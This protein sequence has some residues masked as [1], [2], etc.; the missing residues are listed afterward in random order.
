[1]CDEDCW[2]CYKCNKRCNGFK[3]IVFYKT[4]TT[5][6]FYLKRLVLHH[7][8]YRPHFKTTSVK[9]PNKL[10]IRPYMHVYSYQPNTKYKLVALGCVIPLG[11]GYQAYTVYKNSDGVWV[12]YHPEKGVQPITADIYSYA[13]NLQYE[14]ITD[15]EFEQIP[16]VIEIPGY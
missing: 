5:L 3:Q 15:E 6:M 1:M 13:T 8:G 10:D 14:Q 11:D 2:N 12:E 9:I 7:H 4:N 16:T